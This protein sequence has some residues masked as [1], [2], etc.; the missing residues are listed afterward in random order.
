MFTFTLGWAGGLV[1]VNGVVM[2]HHVTV[3]Y[4]ATA[5]RDP[6]QRCT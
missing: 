3:A 6:G 2:V 4:H 5:T 1:I